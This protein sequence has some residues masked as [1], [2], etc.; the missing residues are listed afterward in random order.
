MGIFEFP[1][2]RILKNLSGSNRK[3]YILFIFFELDSERRIFAKLLRLPRTILRK[4]NVRVI[5]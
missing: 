4:L 3:T 2:T 5:I 1:G